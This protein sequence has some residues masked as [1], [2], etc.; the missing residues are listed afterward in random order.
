MNARSKVKSIAGI[1][2]TITVGLAIAIAASSHG[3]AG[4]S[5]DI[6]TSSN[7]SGS[8]S[9]GNSGTSGTGTAGPSDSGGSTTGSSSTGDPAGYG[10]SGASTGGSTTGSSSTGDPAG[11]G[12]SYGSGYADNSSGTSASGSNYPGYL[13][14]VNGSQSEMNG[15]IDDQGPGITTD[16]R[17][18]RCRSQQQRS[19]G[20]PASLSDP[21]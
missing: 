6:P 11:Y 1:A 14:A 9:S 5:T 16:R 13:G 18:C 2:I 20:R 3:S 15:A 10:S 12:N 4:S 17:L 8:T 7:V 21:L 19:S